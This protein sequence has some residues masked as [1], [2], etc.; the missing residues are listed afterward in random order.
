MGIKPQT[1]SN[2]SSG[3]GCGTN[4]E[5]IFTFKP[6][7]GDKSAKIAENLGTNFM[8]RQQQHLDKQKRNVSY[9]SIEPH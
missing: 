2:K 7:L 6:K 3:K 1:D 5:E 8:S 9:P 4:D